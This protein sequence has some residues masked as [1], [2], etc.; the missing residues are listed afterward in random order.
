[1]AGV[2]HSA[3]LKT[4]ETLRICLAV[5]FFFFFSSFLIGLQAIVRVRCLYLRNPRK[6]RR[7]QR[8]SQSFQ[9]GKWLS[10]KLN[11]PRGNRA[12][13]IR[14]CFE[15]GT[16][17]YSRCKE[18]L[19]VS[20]YSIANRARSTDFVLLRKSI[21]KQ[22]KLNAPISFFFFFHTVN[23]RKFRNVLS[24]TTSPSDL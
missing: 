13:V 16:L 17:L 21:A 14:V 22:M 24:I 15:N 7:T 19:R 4:L 2:A 9:N 3:T 11:P 1:M 12:V 23:N 5:R 20:G 10:Y 8:C 6:L 18:K